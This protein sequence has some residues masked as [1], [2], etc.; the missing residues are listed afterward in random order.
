MMLALC[1][2][3]LGSSFSESVVPEKEDESQDAVRGNVNLE[4][5]LRMLTGI[6]CLDRN[7]KTY[8]QSAF[9]PA[10][11]PVIATPSQRHESLIAWYLPDSVG[12]LVFRPDDWQTLQEFLSILQWVA[13]FNVLRLTET[14]GLDIYMCASG[15][16][17]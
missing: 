16:P 14:K 7:F 2:S 5:R 9:G 11:F 15:A 10:G 6:Y 3:V 4:T 12:H 13:L 17:A 1:Y 8:L